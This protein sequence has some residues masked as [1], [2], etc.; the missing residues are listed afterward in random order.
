SRMRL[1]HLVVSFLVWIGS[2]AETSEDKTDT[3]SK[4]DPEQ[5]SLPQDARYI[6]Y[7]VNRGE[8]FN[9]RRDVHMRVAIAVRKL[10]E[11]GVN[12]ILVLPPWGGLYHWRDRKTGVRWA[13]LFDV[14]S[15]N[16]FVPSIEFEQ[17]LE[18]ASSPTIDR[19][20]YLQHFQEGWDGEYVMKSEKRP[21]MEGDKYYEKEDGLWKGWFYGLSAVRARDLEC[22]SFQGD[23]ESFAELLARNYTFQSIFVDRAETMLHA[24]YGGVEYWR[25]RRSMR[26]SKLLEARA[27]RFIAGEM[28]EEIDAQPLT[29]RW[30]DEKA[31][32][33]SKGGS[34][35]AVHWRRRDFIQAYGSLLPSI[36]GTAKQITAMAKE[37]GVKKAFV[38][39]D[40]EEGDIEELRKHLKI[41]L[42]TFRPRPDEQLIDGAAAIVEQI[43]CSWAR[44]FAGSYVSTFSF[45]IQEDREIR[46]FPVETTFRRMCPDDVTMHGCEQPA[47]WKIVY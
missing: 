44:V 13:D 46:G 22:V 45:R 10:R 39:T 9:L 42:Y 32:R 3:V 35:V 14:P 5:F 30:E 24:E 21:C 47:K 38:A 33:T 15:L 25:A 41:T 12:A 11:K 8:G 40:A 27:E 28:K 6:M 36:K 7:D 16:S 29:E 26:Y 20:V 19:I 2:Q 18:V 34:Y 1:L 31:S 37:F 17:F 4:L 23:S 43:I